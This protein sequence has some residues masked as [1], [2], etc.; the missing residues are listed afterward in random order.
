MHYG[1]VMVEIYL[2]Q[3][4]KRIATQIEQKIYFQQIVNID[5]VLEDIGVCKRLK[6][7][8]FTGKLLFR[9]V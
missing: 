2:K 4:R 9:E 7:L 6:K 1:K 3:L 5:A 8:C